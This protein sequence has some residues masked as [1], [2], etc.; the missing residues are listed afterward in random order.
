MVRHH[1]PAFIPAVGPA[2][3]VTALGGR[4]ARRP[5]LT[6]GRPAVG[7]ARPTPSRPA[8][9]RWT[10]SAPN[11][12]SP[13]P[14]SPPTPT[15]IRLI[16]CDCDGTLLNAAC[17]TSATNIA[18]VRAAMAAGIL[19]V[20]ATGKSRYGA[21]A[22]LG[23]LG[24]DLRAA[25]PN[26]V[27]GVYLQGLNVFGDDGSMVYEH[28]VTPKLAR[29]IVAEARAVNSSLIAYSG[30]RILCE[31]A[32]EFT[33]LLPTYAEPVPE[34]VGTWESVLDTVPLNKFIYLGSADHITA[35]RPAVE[36]AVGAEATIT[37]ALPDML[38]VLPPG[39][40]KGDGVRRLLKG[41]F[42]GVDPAAVMAL[43]DA[44][45][46]ISMF[47]LVG[48]SVAVANALPALKIIA[49]A[50]TERTNVEDGVAEA[51]HTF[52]LDPLAKKGGNG[53]EAGDAESLRAPSPA[54]GG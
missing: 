17:S 21:L 13:P 2:G 29:A 24:D 36:E 31:T 37:Q 4:A 49:T 26:G 48:T 10:A 47:R 38:E 30:D 27:P 6:V 25:Y 9:A 8:A 18:A 16:T 44:E 22:A 40:S 33:D 15:A 32:D 52:I 45:N 54:A 41:A 42:G 35:L 12:A 1:G 34:V 5:A 39:A 23:D 51:I 14:P 3:A 46:D 11:G 28:T 7:V 53:V 19:F 43:G 20:P 50:V